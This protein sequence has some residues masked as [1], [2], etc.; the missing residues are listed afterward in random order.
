MYHIYN[1]SILEN[2]NAWRSAYEIKMAALEHEK[3]RFQNI[4]NGLL[5]KAQ[6]TARY[7]RSGWAAILKAPLHL[8]AVLIG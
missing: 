2:R 5:G 1:T 4:E 6:V 7:R 8:I 3:R